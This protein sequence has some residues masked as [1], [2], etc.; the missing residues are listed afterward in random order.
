MP[1]SSIPDALDTKGFRPPIGASRPALVNSP[2]LIRS[3]RETRPHD[4][5]RTISARL[6]LAFSAAFTRAFDAFADRNIPAIDVA[7]FASWRRA[8]P[9]G[10]GTGSKRRHN[11]RVLPQTHE[12]TS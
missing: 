5:S 3:R 11:Q 12:R 4:S 10:D 9:G 6:L 8:T 1:S 2:N 7:P